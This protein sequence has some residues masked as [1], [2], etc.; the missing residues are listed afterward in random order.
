[1]EK[2]ALLTRRE[3]NVRDLLASIRKDAWTE[4]F[5][6]RMVTVGD[7]IKNEA[8]S[9][10][11]F[12]RFRRMSSRMYSFLR[13]RFR[14]AQSRNCCRFRIAAADRFILKVALPSPLRIA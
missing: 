10:F 6:N 8:Q 4:S 14:L 3:G 7:G 9:I 11:A 2:Q 5:F 1:M 13:F 12:A